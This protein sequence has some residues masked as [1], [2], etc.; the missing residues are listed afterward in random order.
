[1]GRSKSTVFFCFL[2]GLTL[3]GSTALQ[4]FSPLSLLKIAQNPARAQGNAQGLQL[5]A[6]A[7][8]NVEQLTDLRSQAALWVGIAYGYGHLGETEKALALFDR[9]L[10]LGEA[11]WAGDDEGRDYRAYHEDQ[12]ARQVV[13]AMTGLGW[14]DRALTLARTIRP[15]LA[16]AEALHTIAQGLI[17]SG[18]TRQGTTIALEALRVAKGVENY[19]FGYEGNGS[20]ANYKYEALNAIAATLI[21]LGRVNTALAGTADVQSCYAASHPYYPAQAYRSTVYFHLINHTNSIAT[22]NQVLAATQSNISE[23]EQIAVWVAVAEGFIAQGRPDLAVGVAEKIA[24]LPVDESSF[25]PYAIWSEQINHL[26]NIAVVLVSEGHRSAADQVSELAAGPIAQWHDWEQRNP[27]HISA[28]PENIDLAGRQDLVFKIPVEIAWARYRADQGNRDQALDLLATHWQRLASFEGWLVD[29]LQEAVITEWFRLGESDRAWATL[30]SLDPSRR[31]QLQRNLIY[32][33]V[34]VAT[35]EVSDRLV[36]ETPLDRLLYDLPR[37]IANQTEPAVLDQLWGRIQALPL[38]GWETQMLMGDLAAQFFQVGAPEQGKKV[39]AAITDDFPLQA[40]SIR[41][42][43]QGEI[44]A[45][46]EVIS[47]IEDPM[48]QA[49][50]WVEGAIVFAPQP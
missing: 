48:V 1:M 33:L 37:W 36:A 2:L 19:S 4:D 18:D 23:P 47:R 8:A 29:S 26:Q 12:T 20:C 14:Y 42:L 25:I 50:A 15:D 16:E 30:A 24:A 43:G 10:A 44:A 46:L 49:Q 38:E 35:P 31:E 40:L 11:A 41:L 22:L 45:A 3:G 34:D 5:L 39:A 6:Q 13:Q 7:E 27:E 28:L 21:D 9:A 17:S 32:P